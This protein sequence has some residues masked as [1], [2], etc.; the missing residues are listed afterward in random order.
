MYDQAKLNKHWNWLLKCTILYVTKTLIAFS[1]KCPNEGIVGQVWVV[2][3]Y[4]RVL[5]QLW[6]YQEL[7]GLFCQ[8]V[9][10]LPFNHKSRVHWTFVPFVLSNAVVIVLT[11][12]EKYF[13]YF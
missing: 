10:I 11:S 1:C 12:K 7:L 4:V 13:L 5:Y 2:E 9:N 8:K 3:N 6:D